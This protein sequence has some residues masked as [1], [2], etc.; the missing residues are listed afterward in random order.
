MSSY[1]TCHH[2]S[3][4]SRPPLGGDLVPAYGP[5]SWPYR[6][7]Q[8]KA[9][10]KTQLSVVTTS[11][12]SH[13]RRSCA[14]E[15]HLRACN[16]RDPCWPEEQ[17]LDVAALPQLQGRYIALQV[18]HGVSMVDRRLTTCSQTRTTLWYL[19]YVNHAQPSPVQQ[20]RPI[21]PYF[22]PEGIG[23]IVLGS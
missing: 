5:P 15:G 3:F 11:H 23:G 16:Q 9:W 2:I 20:Y 10:P 13:N 19:A 17:L 6:F 12:E 22:R 7:S 14:E 18:G 8:S 21:R 1:S 4:L